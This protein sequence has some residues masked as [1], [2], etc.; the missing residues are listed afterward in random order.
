MQGLNKDQRRP[1]LGMA[2]TLMLEELEKQGIVTGPYQNEAYIEVEPVLVAIY[3]KSPYSTN[4]TCTVF[5]RVLCS[6]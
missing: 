3:P 2:G 1:E 5:V 4:C 6:R